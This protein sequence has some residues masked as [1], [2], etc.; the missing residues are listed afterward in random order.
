MNVKTKPFFFLSRSQN[1]SRYTTNLCQTR[2]LQSIALR[3]EDKSHWERRVAL[4]PDTISRLMKETGV[5]VYVQPCNKRIFNNNKF[6]N[7]GAIVQEDISNAD[8]ILGIK[9]VPTKYLIPNKTYMF[10][11]HTHKGQLY[12]MPMLQDILDKKIRLIDYEL[13]TDAQKRRLVLFGTHAGYAGMIDGLHGLGRRLLGLGY[14]TPFMH[15]AMSHTYKSLD[16]AKSAVKDIGVTIA[17]EGLPND[18]S[19]MTFVFTG[20]GNVSNG[21]QDIFKCLPHEYVQVKDLEECAMTSHKFSSHKVYGCQVHLQDYLIRTDTGKFGTKRDYYENPQC[22]NSLFHTK[23]APYTSMLI[24]G[25]Y[26]DS[27]F[28]R[29]ITKEQL[30]EIQKNSNN[31]R[32]L[33]VAD[34]SCDI[35]GALEFLSH[36]TTID[37][38]FFY[39]DAVKNEEHKKDEGEGTQ[40]MA[41]DILPTEIPLESSEHFSR[42]LYPFIKDLVNGTIDNNPVLSNA[43][44][45]KDGRLVGAH[46]KLYELL[47]RNSRNNLSKIREMEIISSF[48]NKPVVSNHE[49]LIRN[50]NISI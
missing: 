10:F 12:N 48:V 35:E 23:I 50:S 4:T 45:A 40:I 39:F 38:P 36:S 8:V 44:I 27:R 18:F 29:L 20:T 13:M 47:P 28:P 16:S 1:Y 25:S 5:K 33:C 41:V 31:R 7:A 37:D 15:I 11:S 3:R 9:E 26:W 14:N 32:L 43:T 6:I 34:I 21:V 17:D 19:P 24:H 22:Y 30:C 49:S 2:C 42:S 46:T